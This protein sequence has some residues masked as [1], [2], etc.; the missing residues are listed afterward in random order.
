MV[1]SDMADG[2]DAIRMGMGLLLVRGHK[3]AWEQLTSWIWV[4]LGRGQHVAM[5][6]NVL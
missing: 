5:G 6:S 4:G 3:R 2:A 1:G